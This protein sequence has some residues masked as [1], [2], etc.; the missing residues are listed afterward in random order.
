MKRT[1]RH[2]PLYVHVKWFYVWLEV[3]YN[4]ELPVGV[5]DF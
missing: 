5:I 4:R 2:P 3:A 1:P